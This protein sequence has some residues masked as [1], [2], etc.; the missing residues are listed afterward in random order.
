MSNILNHKRYTQNEINEQSRNDTAGRCST[1]SSVEGD[2]TG[3]GIDRFSSS[4]FIT[5]DGLHALGVTIVA[6]DGGA[7]FGSSTAVLRHH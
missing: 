6:Y 2:K 5:V 7:A 3:D 4:V 1:Q